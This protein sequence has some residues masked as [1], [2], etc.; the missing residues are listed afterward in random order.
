MSSKISPSTM[1][2]VTLVNQYENIP[3]PSDEL[4]N[5][6]FEDFNNELNSPNHPD[7]IIVN[8]NEN[9]QSHFDAS[10]FSTPHAI[11]AFLGHESATHVFIQTKQNIA[12]FVIQDDSVPLLIL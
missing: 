4:Y 12:V 6:F 7:A 10:Y 11:S 3:E 9:T 1:A 8:T 2:L 5:K